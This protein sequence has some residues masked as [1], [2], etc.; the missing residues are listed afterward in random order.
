MGVILGILGWLLFF[1]GG[2]GLLILPGVAGIQA[3]IVMVCGSVMLGAGHVG[4]RVDAMRASLIQATTPG[5]QS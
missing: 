3:G 1:G 4:E 5:E 2:A